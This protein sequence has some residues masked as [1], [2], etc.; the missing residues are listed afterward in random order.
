MT[1]TDLSALLRRIRVVL[2]DFDGP[3]CDV[4][5]AYPAPQV[6]ADLRDHLNTHAI[7]VPADL[8]HLDDPLAL[9]RR[10]HQHAPEHYP[11][12]EAFLTRAETHAAAHAA[13]TPG[14]V[15]V[16]TTC[17]HQARPVAVVSNNS[18]EAI[19]TFLTCHGLDTLVAGV[20]GRDKTTPHRL[21]PHP[22]LL[23][24]AATTLDIPHRECLMVGDSATDIQAAHTLGMSALGYVNH[25]GKQNAFAQLGCE[26]VITHMSALAHA[27][28]N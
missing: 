9:I 19:H 7:P 2:L 8:R 10:L 3:V 25:P 26:A 24:L 4:F 12:A 14:A 21:K 18:P 16:L 15:E 27:L 6:A 11:A 20:F 5:S 1:G 13:P 17:T 22:H 23:D 28:Q